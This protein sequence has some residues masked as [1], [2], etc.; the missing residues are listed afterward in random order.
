MYEN[1]KL[2]IICPVCGNIANMFEHTHYVCTK[3]NWDS[4]VNTVDISYGDNLSSP[5]SNL[6][7]HNFT[8]YNSISPNT[9][10]YCLSMESF[11][12]SLR[13][14][15]AKLQ[16]YICENY[17]GYASYKLRLSLNDW[18]KDGIVY[19]Q[20]KPINRFSDDYKLLITEA[21]NALYEGNDV[22]RELVLP[23]F[24]DCHLIHSFGGQ[25]QAE[26]LLTQDEYLWQLK[27]LIK[28]YEDSH[29]QKEEG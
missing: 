12:Q 13:V 10:I 1:S 14:S 28:R 22:F 11:L 16:K 9:C 20:G 21:Y 8:I 26:T 15:D 29:P 24:K 17:S 2:S 19:W 4:L 5:L 23:R 3:C 18:R 7:P 27:R 25:I 6:F